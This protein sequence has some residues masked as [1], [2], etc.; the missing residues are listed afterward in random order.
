[1]LAP[2]IVKSLLSI[3]RFTT[4]NWCSMEFDPFGYI[5]LEGCQTPNRVFLCTERGGVGV[6]VGKLFF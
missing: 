3:H 4:D 6:I 5:M 2:N 1:L